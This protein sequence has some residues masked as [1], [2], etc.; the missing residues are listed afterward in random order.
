MRRRIVRGS[1]TSLSQGV[2]K[3]DLGD[4]WLLSGYSLQ[5]FKG[6]KRWKRYWQ[7]SKQWRSKYEE[8]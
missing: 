6:S 8:D 7:D 3:R 4:C 1:L 2:E 5:C